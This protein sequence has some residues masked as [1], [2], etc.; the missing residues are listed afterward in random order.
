MWE[1]SQSP[2]ILQQED[3]VPSS[4]SEPSAIYKEAFPIWKIGMRD[5]FLRHT[6]NSIPR[7]LVG[8]LDMSWKKRK[9]KPRRA[10]AT[11]LFNLQF[12]KL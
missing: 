9:K 11:T 10:T 8:S 5:F 6:I 1:A 2:L 4:R 12:E 3:V 7:K